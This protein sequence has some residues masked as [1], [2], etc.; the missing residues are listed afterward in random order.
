VYTEVKEIKKTTTP[1]IMKS[2]DVGHMKQARLM[3]ILP[4]RGTQFDKE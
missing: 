4:K 3:G 2:K 1:F